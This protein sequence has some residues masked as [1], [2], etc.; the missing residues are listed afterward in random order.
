[1]F[2]VSILEWCCSPSGHSRRCLW[3]DVTYGVIVRVSKN[4]NSLQNY[5]IQVLK[6]KLPTDIELLIACSAV[7]LS[8][9][10]RTALWQHGHFNTP[11]LRNLSSYNDETLQV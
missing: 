10:L 6:V 4:T 7:A 1:M 2:T 9:V 5:V 3:P 11:Q 8:R